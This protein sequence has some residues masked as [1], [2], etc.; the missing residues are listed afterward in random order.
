MKRIT[1]KKPS[2]TEWLFAVL[3]TVLPVLALETAT[4]GSLSDTLS[5]MCREPWLFLMNAAF[6]LGLCLLGCALRGWRL[7][8]GL[9]IGLCGLTALLGVA[10][11]YKMLFRM[12]PLLLTDVWQLGDAVTTVDT[13]DFGINLTEL[14]LIAAA[15]AVLIALWL[16]LMRN[17]RRSRNLPAAALGLALVLLLPGQC[18]FARGG[19]DKRSDMMEHARGE[20]TLY[21]AFAAE[22]YR[23]ARLR[24]DD[25]PEEVRASY[26]K[27]QQQTP[28]AAQEKPNIIVVLSESWSDE[29]WLSQYVSLTRELTPFY[30]Q[31]VQGCQSGRI[32]VPKQGGGTSETE[33]EVLTG[34]RSQYSCNSYS[35]GLPPLNSLASVLK[36][37]GYTASAIHWFQ[38]VYY[39]RYRNL[40]M[41][42]FDDFY[43]TDTT[44]LPFTHISTYIS[45]RDHYNAALERM[46]QTDG[47]DFVFVMTMQNHGGYDY[48]DC[49]QLYGADEPFLGDFSDHTRLVL[50]NY[51]YL[52]QQTDAA[53]RDLIAALESSDEPTVLVWFGDH[54]PPFGADVYQE[55]GIATTGDQ[56]HLTPYFL[57]S[58]R[59]NTPQILDMYANELGACALSAA[60]VNDDPFLTYVDR[61]RQEGQG[62]SL[63][64]Q[65][66]GGRLYDL[67]SYDALFGK[68][69]VYQLAGIS[70]ENQQI[71]IGGSMRM[72][73]FEAV[74]IA[75]AVYL[76]PVTKGWPQKYVLTQNGRALDDSAVPLDA[77]A[78]ALKCQLFSPS[79]SLL[80]ESNTLYYDSVRQLLQAS[81]PLKTEAV[82]LSQN[83]FYQIESQWNKAYEVYRSQS[84]YDQSLALALT[85]DGARWKRAQSYSAIDG[86]LQYAFHEDG[87]L[88]LSIPK[89]SLSGYDSAQVQD[90][91]SQSQGLLHLIRP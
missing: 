68:Q 79:G 2:W 7:R 25:D 71:Q 1:L 14:W 19:G 60:G 32:Y 42:G 26:A 83:G 27:L 9:L 40:R 78:L 52:M 11:R 20:G 84:S 86:G 53:L 5:W 89:G 58:N 28:E 18:T 90:W 64:S 59:G 72:E 80:N 55:L 81:R 6:F 67:L 54:I 47:P 61:L 13:L 48:N 51:C 91:L 66:R 63:T 50:S 8:G 39:N 57:W 29:A 70:P 33:F 56:G 36:K 35:M 45:D 76:R 31:L 41:L 87:T 37:Q 38:G 73:G 69:Y 15:T 34:L 75:D 77:G 22:N 74:Q 49:R 12:E 62:Q 82:A 65:G 24:V 44:N 85:V 46:A 3:G 10:N 23:L 4:R 43:T 17:A 88:Y 30:N 16:W 21:A